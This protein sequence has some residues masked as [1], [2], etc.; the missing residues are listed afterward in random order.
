MLRIPLDFTDDD[1]NKLPQA[2]E[3]LPSENEEELLKVEPDELSELEKETDEVEADAAPDEEP[4]S[5][6]EEIEA[7]KPV[8]NEKTLS[9]IAQ[10][11]PSQ[12]DRYQNFINEYRRLQNQRKNNDLVTGLMTAGAQIGQSAA[13]RYS[14]DFKPDMTGVETVKKMGERPVQDLEEQQVVATRGMQLK[15]M[16]DSHDPKSPQSKLVREYVRTRLNINLPENT[17][18]AD[19]Q[20]LLKLIGK[21]ANQKAGQIVRTYNPATGQIELQVFD[22]ST[23]QLKPL[24]ET[25]GF[26]MQA[27]TNPRTN[28][29]MVV[30]PATGK[31]E[32]TVTGP[33]ALPQQ[34]E[35]E[36]E[37]PLTRENLTAKQQDLLDKG[38]EKFLDDTKDDRNALNAAQGIKMTLESGKEIGGD[39]LREIQNQLARGSGEKGAMTDRDV[40]PFGGRQSLWARLQRLASMG[41]TG[42]LPDED[43]KFLMDVAGVMERRAKTYVD[44]K[45]EFFVNT[46]HQD[47]QSAP[48]LR[49]H[50]L[51][52]KQV[53]KLIGVDYTTQSVQ[54]PEAPKT[55]EET[56]VTADGRKAVFNRKTKKFLRWA[57]EKQ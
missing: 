28:E 22:P 55:D 4:S 7:P 24:G 37:V 19:A 54:A 51:T 20:F 3:E 41:A 40:A 5:S 49:Q 29:V 47:L 46:M 12:L 39:I 27:R 18:A 10:E 14:G 53:R 38:R 13:G 26:A 25:A 42:Q 36:P 35:G 31:Y 16:Q 33:T 21:P 2:E 50:K 17:S 48:N 6:E 45:S 9:D 56:R 30:N 43:R 32:S 52:P 44:N 15:G 11:P 8:F 1:E 34:K 57:D 23:Q